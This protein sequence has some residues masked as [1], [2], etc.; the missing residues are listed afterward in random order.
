MK[1]IPLFLACLILGSLTLGPNAFAQPEFDFGQNGSEEED[2]P[3]VVNPYDDKYKPDLKAD[4]ETGTG[5]LP[6]YLYFVGLLRKPKAGPDDLNFAIF[7][8]GSVMGCLDVEN[9]S[10]KPLK[11]GTNLRLEITDGYIDVDSS[12]IRYFHY[13]CSPISGSSQIHITLS[14]QSL[15]DDNIKKL[16]IVSEQLGPFNDMELD[17]KDHSITVVSKTKGLDRFGIKRPAMSDTFTYWFYPE[18]TYILHASAVGKDD[19]EGQNL[20]KQMVRT[21]NL[22]PLEEL[23]PGFEPGRSNANNIYVVDEK[24][25]YKDKLEHL[26][27]TFQLGTI[28]T[29]EEFYGPQ[30]LYTRAKPASVYARLPGLYE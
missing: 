19:I 22:T 16:V 29:A 26:T 9:P 11:A 13:E 30:G 4:V 28:K 10:I 12:T 21:K 17:I 7:A 6:N 14:K 20:I 24:G 27:D 15:M 8:P 5:V 3:K 1:Y 18:N 23:F 2:K 25:L